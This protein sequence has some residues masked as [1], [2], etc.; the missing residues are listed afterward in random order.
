MDSFKISMLDSRNNKQ[1]KI[2]SKNKLPRHKKGERF[3]KGP[4]PLKWLCRAATKRGKTFH[5]AIALW[6]LASM[7]GGPTVSLPNPLLASF[8][9]NRYAKSRGLK[10]LEAAGLVSVKRN[11]GRNP[12]VT[13]L[14]INE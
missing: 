14:D 13:I 8:G 5:V 11:P 12:V 7:K 4:I 10:Q 3:L 2:V 1:E 9:V 6:H